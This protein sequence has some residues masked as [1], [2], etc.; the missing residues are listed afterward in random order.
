[1]G[2]QALDC[3]TTAVR[4]SHGSGRRAGSDGVTLGGGGRDGAP[5]S[6]GRKPTGLGVGPRENPGHHDA[7]LIAPRGQLMTRHD[8]HVG[9]WMQLHEHSG[10]WNTALLPVNAPEPGQM[11]DPEG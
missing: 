8:L 5:G 11:K 2:S 1:M 10:Y 4:A 9:S 6:T 3:G 7:S